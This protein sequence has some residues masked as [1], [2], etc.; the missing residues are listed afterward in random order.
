[1]YLDSRVSLSPSELNIITTPDSIK[2]ILETKLREMHEGRCN[3][4]GFVK[5]GSLQLIGRSMG[6]AENGRFTGNLLFDCKMS[7]E[8][9]YPTAGSIIDVSII[10]VNK[11]GA[12]AVFEE[13]IRILLPRDLHIGSTEFDA[14]KEGDGV[15]VR[16]DRSRFQ[17]KDAFI[18][19]VGRLHVDPKM[20]GYEEP[21]E[22]DVSE[23]IE[24]SE[25]E[26]EA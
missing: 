20:P 26:Q 3:A 21:K 11:M 15:K 25:E 9:L 7:C 8:V 19:A 12:Y 24:D 10:K 6:V 16:I 1:M 13:A 4:N 22:P 18:M 23:D 5:P 2:D 14:L 17:T